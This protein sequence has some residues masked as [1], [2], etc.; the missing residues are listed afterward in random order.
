[1]KGLSQA[2]SSQFKDEAAIFS[3][4]NLKM[5]LTGPPSNNVQPKLLSLYAGSSVFQMGIVFPK[6]HGKFRN[7]STM[8]I[9]PT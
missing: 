9:A 5:D 3:L 7:V 8:T 2:N 4:V 6:S 1:M